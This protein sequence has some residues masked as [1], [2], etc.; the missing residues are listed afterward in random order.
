MQNTEPVLTTEEQYR[1]ELSRIPVMSET[2]YQE[3]ARCIR[4]ARAGLLD[5]A[6]GERARERMIHAYLWKVA[7]IAKHRYAATV[8]PK[9]SLLDLIQEG[10]H[11]LVK[12][13]DD[14]PFSE[15]VEIGGYV[16][17]Q[18]TWTIL[19]ALYTSHLIRVPDSSYRYALAHGRAQQVRSVH[20]VSSLNE[21][22]TRKRG[23]SDKDNVSLLHFLAT[24]SEAAQ[25]CDEI[26]ATCLRLLLALLIPREREVLAL[27][28]GIGEDQTVYT[29]QEIASR[30]HV[31]PSMVCQY[32]RRA[33]AHIQAIYQAY[34]RTSGQELDYFTTNRAFLAYLQV[35]SEQETPKGLP[36]DVETVQRLDYAYASLHT[37]HCSI[38][39]R[40]LADEAHINTAKAGQYLKLRHEIA[41]QP[42]VFQH[43]A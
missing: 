41:P 22:H 7:F 13:V 32:E 10:N 37:R 35:Q 18:V 43:F 6:S 11:A 2:E 19:H 20:H 30:L 16:H 25:V 39:V 14:F 27:R 26:K 23:K 31:S 9:I 24:P 28:Y 40:S 17:K 4:L 38:T 12:L 21:L 36:L 3:V 15:G 42:V 29:L 1:R 8:E 33:I 34:Q 5:A